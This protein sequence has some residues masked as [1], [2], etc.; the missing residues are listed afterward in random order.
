MYSFEA[1]DLG[2]YRGDNYFLAGFVEPKPT[3]GDDYNPDRDAENYGV[4]LVQ[5]PSHPR[6]GNT[7]IVRMD[8]CHDQ[9]HMDLVYLPPDADEDDKIWLEEGYTY[10]R[11][12]QFL[13]TNWQSF[14]DDHIA[15]NE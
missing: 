11:M 10:N 3:D 13:L 7:Q 15:Y 5:K 8:T 6:E 1:I 9:P 2:T 14:V 12:K 4:T